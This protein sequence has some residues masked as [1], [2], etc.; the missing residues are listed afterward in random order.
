M[1]NMG[2]LCAMFKLFGVSHIVY[3]LLG[4]A[5]ATVLVLTLRKLDSSKQKYAGVTIVSAMGLLVILDIVGTVSVVD[6]MWEHLP[7]N[8]YHILVY[9]AIYSE[10]T[11]S[12]SW[13][14]F[15]YFVAL[16]IAFLQLF[17]VP[18]L[19]TTMSQTGISVISY[20]LLNGLLGT[21][22][23]LRLIWNDEYVDKKDILNSTMN[24][25]IILAIVHIIN[26]ILR[27][28]VLGTDANY[29][30]TMGENFDILIG[31][32]DGL[33][34]VPFVNILLLVAVLVGIEFLLLLPFDIVKTRKDRQNQ[35]EELV[36]LGNLKAQAKYRKSGSSQVLLNSKEKARP[37]T[38]KNSTSYAHRDG[39]VSINKEVN[40]NRDKENK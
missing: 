35:Y 33:I 3:L 31:F 5:V 18:N 21:Y 23:I 36:A 24:L 16:P 13:T 4:L 11:K 2:R 10:I 20:F 7:L 28:T 14:K 17:F 27:F 22:S 37:D 26:V 1:K 40:V 32:V 8:M 6:N 19:Y 12:S 15:G 30:G 39:F 38:Y 25:G 9:L 34:P 29:C